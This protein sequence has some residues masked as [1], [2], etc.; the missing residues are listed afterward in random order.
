M[1]RS[2]EQDLQGKGSELTGASTEGAEQ[3]TGLEGSF[4]RLAARGE[5]RNMG[6]RGVGVYVAGAIVV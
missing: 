3:Q 2:V 1:G 4:L 6:A 5:W